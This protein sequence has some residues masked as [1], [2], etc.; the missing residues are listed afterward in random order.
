MRHNSPADSNAPVRYYNT[1]TIRSSCCWPNNRV[2][3]HRDIVQSLSA[4]WHRHYYQRAAIYNSRFHG[5]IREVV[6]IISNATM[7]YIYGLISK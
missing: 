6:M 2:T 7:Q 1:I 3:L 4:L 5:D